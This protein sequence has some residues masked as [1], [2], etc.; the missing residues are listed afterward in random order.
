MARRVSSHE[1]AI[2]GF[3][4]GLEWFEGLERND[5][6]FLSNRPRFEK[7]PRGKDRIR[8]LRKAQLKWQPLETRQTLGLTTPDGMNDM[9]T[10][11]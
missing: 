2:D 1:T 9:L 3:R 8:E 7:L 4:M 10:A 11:I 6:R 5:G